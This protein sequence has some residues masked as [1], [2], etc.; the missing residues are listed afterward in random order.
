M[1]EVVDIRARRPH[2]SGAVIC[3]ACKH[4]RVGV[5]EPGTFDME[6]PSCSCPRGVWKYSLVP[7]EGSQVWSCVTCDCCVYFLQMGE[8]TKE[9]YPTILTVCTGCGQRSNLLEL[10]DQ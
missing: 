4:E 2:L 7:E 1:G 10:Y 6:C 3:L 5:A 8:R 9:G